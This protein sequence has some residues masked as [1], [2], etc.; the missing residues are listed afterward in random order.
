MIDQVLD[1]VIEGATCVSAATRSASRA[2]S[3]GVQ[4]VGRLPRR[5]AAVVVASADDT[6]D[7]LVATPAVSSAPTAT[8]ASARALFAVAA[9]TE[10]PPISDGAMGSG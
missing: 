1:E 6:A 2:S 9:G 8:T 5:E 10:S 3:S 7:A 4:L